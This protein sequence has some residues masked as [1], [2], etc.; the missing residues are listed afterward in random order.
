MLV[1]AVNENKCSISPSINQS[2][3]IRFDQAA[4]ICH[5]VTLFLLLH[6]FTV[7]LGQE[8]TK[9]I[10]IQIK[11]WTMTV[12]YHFWFLPSALINLSLKNVSWKLAAPDHFF[13]I[14]K[15]C[16]TKHW[17]NCEAWL[18]CLIFNYFLP[19]LSSPL[20]LHA[21]LHTWIHTLIPSVRG[22]PQLNWWGW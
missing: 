21:T 15:Y 1:E 5:T 2:D 13:L 10:N 17:K 11:N 16:E 4:N 20:I 6:V 7:S 22:N 3:Q 19:S 14:F 18:I 9:L 8:I 12:R